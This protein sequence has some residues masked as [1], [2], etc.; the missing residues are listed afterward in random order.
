MHH[1]IALFFLCLLLAVAPAACA[2][3]LPID[4]IVIQTSDGIRHEF[5]VEI[6]VTDAQKIRGLMYRTTLE[7]N[8]GML[9]AF[10]DE[11]EHAFWMKNTLIP[12]DM[13]FVRG[14]GTIHRVHHDAV[15]R[16]L[17][18]IPSNGPVSRVI[19]IKGGIAEKLGIHAGDMVYSDK[20][21]NN[22]RPE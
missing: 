17:T 2:R 7:D 21:F 14:D 1:R 20:Y 18:R 8:K 4:T 15:P 22:K 19:E 12:L 6:P 3:E 10:D 5:T 13:L 11:A 9:F 16:D